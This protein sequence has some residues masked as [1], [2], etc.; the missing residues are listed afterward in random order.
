MNEEIFLSI[1][2]T[3]QVSLF[4]NSNFESL[5][6]QALV[7]PPYPDFILMR[8]WIWCPRTLNLMVNQMKNM[9]VYLVSIRQSDPTE[10][11]NTAPLAPLVTETVSAPFKQVTLKLATRWNV[12]RVSVICVTKTQRVSVWPVSPRGHRV[13]VLPRNLPY[14]LENEFFRGKIFD[15]DYDLSV[16][17]NW[18]LILRNEWS[19]AA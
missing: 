12:V 11:I 2:W 15:I 7:R 1:K 13:T 9:S 10:T 16:N 18:Y 3:F 5:E 19:L 8:Y 14:S 17:L 6:R 4:Q